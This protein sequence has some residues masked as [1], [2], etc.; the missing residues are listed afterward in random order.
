MQVEIRLH[1]IE[2]L[3]TWVDGLG[4]TGKKAVS[5]TVKDI[6]S[7]AP[8]WIANEVTS[9]YNIKKSDI[10]PARTE[11]KKSKKAVS[12][13]SSGQTLETVAI[14][15]RGRRL[16]PIHFSMSPSKPIR[17]KMKDRRVIPGNRVNFDHG[18]SGPFGLVSIYKKY[19]ISYK[20]I[21]GSRRKVR[22][23]SEYETPF[24]APVKKGSDKYIVFQRKKGSK[25]TDMYSIRTVSVPQMIENEHVRDKVEQK[26]M[27]AGAQRLLHHIDRLTS[28]K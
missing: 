24:L 9:E 23:K 1:E 20:V 25:R 28:S 7:R 6:K 27:E 12:V 16:T 11:E 5:Y 4:K 10:T 19:S 26:V 22:G 3:L 14:V 21:K 15:Y 8:G 18:P 13:Y 17:R 2:D